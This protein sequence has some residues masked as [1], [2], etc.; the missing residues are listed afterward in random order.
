MLINDYLKRLCGT[1]TTNESKN[2]YKDE[3]KNKAK[4][5]CRWASGNGSKASFCNR[6]HGSQLTVLHLKKFRC[7]AK[8]VFD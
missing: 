3:W 1:T 2:Q 4:Y 8:I 7:K 6:P 5:H